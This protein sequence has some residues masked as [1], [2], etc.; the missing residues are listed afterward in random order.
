MHATGGLSAEVN[1]NTVSLFVDLARAEHCARE[2]HRLRHQFLSMM[3]QRA[4]SRS[5]PVQA[6]RLGCSEAEQREL[7]VFQHRHKEVF[8]R[9]GTLR[10]CFVSLAGLSRSSGVCVLSPATAP[11]NVR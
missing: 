4:I 9:S 6:R 8:T 1:P 3:G 7:L 5:F 10:T 2:V 11:T